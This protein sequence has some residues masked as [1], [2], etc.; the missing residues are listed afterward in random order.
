MTVTRFRGLRLLEWVGS[1]SMDY[2][3]AIVDPA[4]D[5]QAM[6]WA[7]WSAL[8]RHGGFDLAR[9]KR[10][11][12]DAI[13]HDFLMRRGASLERD[14]NAQGVN[15][16]WL[17]GS[18]WFKAQSKHARDKSNLKTRALKKLGFEVHIWQPGED[19]EP[20]LHALLRQKREWLRAVGEDSIFATE[21]G[22]R[23]LSE[24]A[25]QLAADGTLHLSSLRNG[26]HFAACHFGFAKDGVLYYYMPSYESELYKRSPGK[27][28]LD[29]LLMLS[30]DL[31]F[32]RFDMLTGEHG[33]KRGYD[34]DPEGVRTLVVPRTLIGAVVLRVYLLQRT[35][36]A[37]SSAEHA[38]PAEEGAA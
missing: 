31:K 34:T 6:L 17:D 1:G 20:I 3:D 37:R 18:S 35:V 38:S 19:Y 36:L 15:I 2:A 25:K 30:C 27:M 5:A 13:V 10:V 28:L 21:Q 23:F 22:G 14:E 32:R 16:R 9:F 29:S 7:M 26:D 11:R 33:Y 8:Q 12:A 24:L 4:V